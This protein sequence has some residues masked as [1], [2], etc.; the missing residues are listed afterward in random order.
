MGLANHDVK[1]LYEKRTENDIFS[2]T[3]SKNRFRFLFANITFNNHVTKNQ[4]WKSD[5]FAG[6]RDVFEW[7]VSNCSKHVIP[8]DYICLDETLYPTR[9]FIAFRQYNPKKPARYGM[10]F[11]FINACRYPYTFTSFAYAGKPRNYDLQPCKYYVRGTE[12]TVKT[13]VK[14]LLKSTN[15]SGR[16]LTFDRMYTSVTLANWLLEKN[17]TTVGTFQTNRKGIPDEIKQIGDK[18]KN[19]YKIFWDESDPKL[20]LHSYVVSTKSSGKRNVLMLFTMKPILGAAKEDPNQNPA[21]YK[22]YAFTKGGTDIVDQR[23]GFYSSKAKSRRWTMSTFAYMLDTCRINA[24][25]VYAM[26][27]SKD[28]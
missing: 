22:F 7:F 6:F 5:R 19:L 2:A 28:P 11:K 16:S 10:L 4:R 14:N 24:C 25:T 12:E 18:E 26:N 8:D 27:N 20:N 13:M 9:V 23:I 21:V 17:I 3:M 15:L 1:V